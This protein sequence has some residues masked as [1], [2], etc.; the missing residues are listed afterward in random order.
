MDAEAAMIDTKADESWR[1]VDTH[2]HFQ[3]LATGSYP[4]LDPERPEPL[5]G[6][7]SPIRRGYL[8]SDYRGDMAGLDVVK[9]VHVQNGRNPDDPLD[10]TRWLSALAEREGAPDAIV[11]FA[12]LAD[13]D[14]ARLLEAHAAFPRV[15]GVRQILNWHDDSRLRTASS[16]NLMDSP[17]WRSGFGRLATLGLSFD[18]QIFWPQMDM[19]LALARA[20]PDTAIV[21]DHFGMI[22][23]RSQD[24]IKNWLA[25]IKRLAQAPNVHVKLSGFGLGNPKWSLN[26][27]LPVLRHSLEVFGPDRTMV[28]TNIPV[29]LLF[30]TPEKIVSAIRA[31]VWDLPEH[32]R[33]A[34]L[35][36][37]A[38]RVYRI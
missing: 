15:R 11:V 19:A 27:T 1:I 3:E 14:V 22:A 34:I 24:G 37:N 29:D 8:P 26:D 18:L 28:G 2:Q 17:R 31:V 21:L 7:L 6:D 35:R 12:N 38:E 32:E 25:A 10:E 33:V 9:T 23:D 13:P 4:W 16:A 36:G 30:A 5:E 20:F